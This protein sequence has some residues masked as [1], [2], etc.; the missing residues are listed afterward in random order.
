MRRPW[1]FR[2]GGALSIDVPTFRAWLENKFPQE[3]HGILWSGLFGLDIVNDRDMFFAIEQDPPPFSAW[4]EVIKAKLSA[5]P[6]TIENLLEAEGNRSPSLSVLWAR[7]DSP[8]AWRY[9]KS[10]V[11]GTEPDGPPP[12]MLPTG[13]IVE[14]ASNDLQ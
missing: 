14:V 9:F 1:G 12:Y 11:A 2:L 10:W 3:Q 7:Y 13:E 6:D 8:A 5:L 4:V